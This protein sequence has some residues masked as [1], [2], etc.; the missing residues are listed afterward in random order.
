MAGYVTVDHLIAA[1]DRAAA[2]QAALD[3]SHRLA[4]A[5]AFGDHEAARHRDVPADQ[6]GPATKGGNR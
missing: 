5:S 2:S 1:L 6:A 4:A 3:E